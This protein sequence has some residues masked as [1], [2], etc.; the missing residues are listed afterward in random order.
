MSEQPAHDTER[1]NLSEYTIAPQHSTD[2]AQLDPYIIEGVAYSPL[3]MTFLSSSYDEGLELRCDSC[4]WTTTVGDLP[5]DSGYI[6][7][8]MCPDCAK[9]GELGFVRCQSPADGTFPSRWRDRRVDADTG[10]GGPSDD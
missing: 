9:K 1:D 7:P 8:D 3:K 6:Q 5:Q 4:E 2:L 10:R